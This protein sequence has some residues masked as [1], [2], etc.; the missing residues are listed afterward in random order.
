MIFRLKRYGFRLWAESVLSKRM[1]GP[2]WRRR[3]R[4]ELNEIDARHLR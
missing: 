4:L 3:V 1:G 2:N